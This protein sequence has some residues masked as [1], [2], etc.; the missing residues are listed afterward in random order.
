M[1][2]LNAIHLL[3]LYHHCRSNIAAEPAAFPI[4]QL[5]K[6]GRRFFHRLIPLLR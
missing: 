2:E 4:L 6:Q 5:H 3:R 1:T